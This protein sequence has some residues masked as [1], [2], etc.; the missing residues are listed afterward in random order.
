MYSI[1][2]V[3]TKF[4]VTYDTLR[5]YEKRGLL[6]NIERDKNGRRIYSEENIDDLNK[7]IHLRH[8]G[9]SIAETEQILNLFG[10]QAKSVEAY[11]AG[12]ELLDQLEVE[13]NAKIEGLKQQQVFLQKKRQ[14]FEQERSS[15]VEK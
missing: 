1:K 11:D 14:K 4:N 15:L 2:E 8:L 3:A 7:L 5:Y 13:T 9:A 10:T 6:T 12:I